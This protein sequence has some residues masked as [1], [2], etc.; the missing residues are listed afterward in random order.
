VLARFDTQGMVL[1]RCA[2]SEHRDTL[3]IGSASPH[4]TKFVTEL[5]EHR[6]VN[7]KPK[8]LIGDVGRLNDF[9]HG[10]KTIAV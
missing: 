10:F 2:D 5:I 6:I 8:R 3:C 1:D 7:G 4:E 9:S